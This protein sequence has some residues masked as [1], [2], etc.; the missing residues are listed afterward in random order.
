MAASTV[1][2]NTEWNF[3]LENGQ[4]DIG[5]I[6]GYSAMLWQGGMYSLSLMR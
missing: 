3:L 2:S 6:C 4:A 1:C 5:G